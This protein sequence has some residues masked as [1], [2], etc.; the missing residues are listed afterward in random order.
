[1]GLKQP[2][3]C[4]MTSHTLGRGNAARVQSTELDLSS[5]MLDRH[6]KERMFCTPTL[7]CPQGATSFF[8][9]FGRSWPT[10][11]TYRLVI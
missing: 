11:W 7:G 5:R 10:T 9:D 1:M 3:L 4:S 6:E 8:V 2:S